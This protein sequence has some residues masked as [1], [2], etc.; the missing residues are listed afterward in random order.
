MPLYLSL[1][2]TDLIIFNGCRTRYK[3]IR[4]G[5]SEP[6]RVVHKLLVISVSKFSVSLCASL[7]YLDAVSVLHDFYVDTSYPLLTKLKPQIES[8]KVSIMHA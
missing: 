5:I 4:Q 8:H 7:C 2:F 6:D 3:G 1:H